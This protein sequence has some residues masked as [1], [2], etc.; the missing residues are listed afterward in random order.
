MT[1]AY[2]ANRRDGT[3]TTSGVIAI[4]NAIGSYSLVNRGVLIDADDV[5]EIHIEEYMN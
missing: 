5:L 4:D 3:S 1:V 2:L